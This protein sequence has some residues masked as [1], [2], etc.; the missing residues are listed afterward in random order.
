[1]DKNVFLKRNQ[2]GFNTY[3]RKLCNGCKDCCVIVV[4]T[5]AGFGEVPFFVVGR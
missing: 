2:F 5:F 3:C 4:R 1:M